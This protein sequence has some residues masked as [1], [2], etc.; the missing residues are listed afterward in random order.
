MTHEGLP[1]E[2][3]PGA[4]RPARAP[5][6]TPDLI[7]ELQVQATTLTLAA[8]AVAQPDVTRFVFASD[9]DPLGTLNALIDAGGHPIGLV[10]ARVGGG[11]VEYYT[12]PF[13][14]YQDHPRAVAYLQ[15]LRIPFLTLLRTHVERLPDHPRWN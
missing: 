14:E 1:E 9:D 7:V 13:A 12:H 11:R 6:T 4:Q 15:T 5:R 3:G 2:L 8:I 10:G